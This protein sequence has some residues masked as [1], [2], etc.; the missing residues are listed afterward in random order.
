MKIWAPALDR[1]QAIRTLLGQ[2]MIVT[3]AYRDPEYNRRVGGDRNSFHLLGSAFDISIARS[4]DLGP[5]IEQLALSLGA[6]DAPIE[7][8]RY[9]DSK[10]I[11]LA[12]P[13][14][15]HTKELTTWGT[16]Y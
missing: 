14:D 15:T 8:G 12:W 5:A 4:P 13:T 9:P 7:I 1:L 10:F 6:D 11:H 3:S 16:W 2:P